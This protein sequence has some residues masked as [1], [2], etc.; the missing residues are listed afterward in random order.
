MDSEELKLV[1]Y[2]ECDHEWEHHPAEWEHLSG[3]ATVL[4]YAESY[5]CHKCD[6][7]ESELD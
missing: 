2:D 5:Y 6:T 1:D 7:W 3:R 4:Q